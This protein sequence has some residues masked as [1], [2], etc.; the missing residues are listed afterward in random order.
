MTPTSQWHYGARIDL[1][2]PEAKSLYQFMRR[3][4]DVDLIIKP[5]CF[6]RQDAKK[7]ER[8]ITQLYARTFGI[9]QKLLRK[10]NLKMNT[11]YRPSQFYSRLKNFPKNTALDVFKLK[12]GGIEARVIATPLVT[13]NIEKD[14]RGIFYRT[15]L[16][17]DYTSPDVKRTDIRIRKENVLSYRNA[18]EDIIDYVGGIL[19]IK[20][21]RFED[22]KESVLAAEIEDERRFKEFTKPWRTKRRA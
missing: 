22:Q 14:E 7:I 3:Q 9:S 12:D 8:D 2:R 6:S 19:P 5:P 16:E 13:I 4:K 15:L 11:P 10:L 21:S 1:N 18:R 17:R 20:N